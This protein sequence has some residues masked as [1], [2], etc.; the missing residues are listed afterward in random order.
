[1][2]AIPSWLVVK[3]DELLPERSGAERDAFARAIVAAIPIQAIAVACASGATEVLSEHGIKD[4]GRSLAY[5]I[6]A[7]AMPHVGR[8]VTL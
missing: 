6:A 1:M 4:D 2:S 7:A 8:A 5:E 3:L